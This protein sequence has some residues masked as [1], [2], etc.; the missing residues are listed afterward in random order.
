M[1]ITT[2]KE[3]KE[4]LVKYNIPPEVV[5]DVNKRISDWLSSGGNLDDPYIKQQW[6]YIE[7]YINVYR[8]KDR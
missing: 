5:N 2:H 8:S 1:K 4:A 7:N 3:F 6:K